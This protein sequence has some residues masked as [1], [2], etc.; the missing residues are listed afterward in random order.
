LRYRIEYHN[1]LF[2]RPETLSIVN[3]RSLTLLKMRG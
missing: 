1:L 3:A 2:P